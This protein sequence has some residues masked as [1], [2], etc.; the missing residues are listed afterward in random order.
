MEIAVDSIIEL[1]TECIPA[2]VKMRYTQGVILF[3]LVDRISL[4]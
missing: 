4:H 1:E 2:I 3:L